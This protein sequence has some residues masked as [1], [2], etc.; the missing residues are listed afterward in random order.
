[1]PN[2]CWVCGPQVAL[3]DAQGRSWA[4]DD[5]IKAAAA[6]LA[7]GAI[8]AIKG[9]GGFHLAVDGANGPAVAELRR[10]K[11]REEKPLALMVK[12]VAAISAL[13]QVYPP[14]PAQLTSPRRPIVLLRKK[15]DAPIAVEVAPGNQF[16]GVMLPYAPLHYRLFD[17]GLFTAL[18][19]TTG[20]ISEEP[21]V[22]DNAEAMARLS[23]I[24]DFFLVNNRDIYLR[25]DDSVMRWLDG[26][27]RL[28]R[29]SRGFAPQPVF[30][31]PHLRPILGYGAEKKNTVCLAYGENAFL[32]QHV[33]D[34]E[35]LETLDYLSLTVDHLKR[36]MSIEPEIVAHDLHPEYLSTKY[37][38]TLTG[39]TLVGVQHH[40]AH[41][42]SCLAEHGLE[43]RV[44]GVALD[45]TGYGT[46]G[47]L[48][49]AEVLVVNKGEFSR[50]AQFAYLPLPGGEAAIR[51]PW[52]MAVSLLNHTYG[53]ESI[54][55]DLPVMRHV[56]E[57]KIR[58]IL[59]MMVRQV[60][61]P[62]VSSCG[63][64]FDGVASLIGLRHDAAYE[65][66][67][68][69]ELEMIAAADLAP[70]DAGYPMSWVRESSHRIVDL[71]QLTEALV[72]DVRHGV[73][74]DVISRR[75]HAGLIRLF[76]G[77]CLEVAEET[78]IRTVVLS[79]GVFMNAIILTGLTA[80]LNQAGFTVYSNQEVPTNDGGIAL[81]Q[82][83]AAHYL[84]Q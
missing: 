24:A 14:E 52:R 67:A 81:G 62:L 13:A 31:K 20:N 74:P 60:N 77:L 9:L 78:G 36:I 55:V 53:P 35:N 71:K 22:I 76:T 61:S 16:F 34:L 79:G 57:S 58:F 27:P 66:Q 1:Q 33:G 43:E 80:S 32:S 2:A 23:R 21:I 65:G 30:L 29:R 69:I 75:F 11:H 3:L 4:E 59:Q 82:V 45:G 70:L 46:D 40:H 47:R 15:A 28:I 42:L 37:A 7:S 49:G 63:R 48:W 51:E 54:P 10:R 6:H 8:L 17:A 56:P 25:T 50:A 72:A 84:T 68:A 73:T 38:L 39:V 5:P 41:I 19:M 18:V 64:L 83:L 26:R 12:D 44:I